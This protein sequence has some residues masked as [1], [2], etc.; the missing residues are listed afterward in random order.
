MKCKWVS[1]GEVV[2][3]RKETITPK[4]EA[5][6][7]HYSLP[8]F[9]AGKGPLYE[10]GN[11]IRSSKLAV[12]KGD[13]L[14]NKLNMRFKR[15]WRVEED[16]PN[17]IC[18]TEFIPLQ[19][20]GIDRDYLYYL[21]LT[22]DF[23]NSMIAQRSGTSNSHQRIKV[24]QLLAY[25]FALPSPDVQ[26]RVGGILAAIDKKIALN[27]RINGHLG[28][29]LVP[30]KPSDLWQRASGTIRHGIRCAGN[31]RCRHSHTR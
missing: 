22:D 25:E 31:R 26:R 21:L 14:C 2:S 17:S 7:W 18:S 27:S 6:Y 5:V 9:D 3:A 20:R 10:C 28:K 4:G 23:T 16:L 12:L 11:A 13:I 30:N 19:A 29:Q 1:L 15:I 24:D 8:A